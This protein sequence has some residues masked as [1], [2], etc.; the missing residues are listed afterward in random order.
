MKRTPAEWEA[1]HEIEILNADGWKDKSLL[2]PIT[3]AEFNERINEST[4]YPLRTKVMPVA[5]CC[6]YVWWR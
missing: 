4:I 6:G 1:I 3:E 5:G 2:E